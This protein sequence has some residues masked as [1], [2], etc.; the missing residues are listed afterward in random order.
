[1]CLVMLFNRNKLHFNYVLDCVYFVH[2]GDGDG[3]KVYFH[4]FIY[5]WLCFVRIK[6]FSIYVFRTIG[7]FKHLYH[8]YNYRY[9]HEQ[10]FF[11]HNRSFFHH[12]HRLKPTPRDHHIK[13]LSRI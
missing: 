7:D 4:C 6:L 12:H 1:M 9:S 10:H 2:N 11:H 8:Q 3:V 5:H 13:L